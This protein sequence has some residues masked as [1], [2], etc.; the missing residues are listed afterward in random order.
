MRITRVVTTVVEVVE[1][2]PAPALAV[3]GLIP[4]GRIAPSTVAVG[5]AAVGA[6]SATAA[7]VGSKAVRRRAALGA[8]RV[9][10]AL[11]RLTERRHG[12]LPGA[13]ATAL[14]AL[15]APVL[16]MAGRDAPLDR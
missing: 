12:S 3:H 16:G 8:S 9:R 1:D 15:P 10:A 5:A 7:L 13:R 14:R 2:Q 4:A 6:I 11:G